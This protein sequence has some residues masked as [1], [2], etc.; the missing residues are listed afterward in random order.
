MNKIKKRKKE[1]KLLKKYINIKFQ[2]TE[3]VRDRQKGSRR[4]TRYD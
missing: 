3:I 1:K 2:R 4:R